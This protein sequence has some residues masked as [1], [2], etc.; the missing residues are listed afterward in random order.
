MNQAADIYIIILLVFGLIYTAVIFAYTVGWYKLKDFRGPS[1]KLPDIKASIIV[2]VRNEEENIGYLLQDLYKQDLPESTFEVIIADDDSTDSTVKIV[3]EFK[4]K[5]TGFQLK[6]LKMTDD[7]ES[8]A[9]KKRAIAEAI[10][11]SSGELIIT[12]D[13]DCRMGNQ[14]LKTL[15]SF[16]DQEKPKMIIGPVVFHH[17]KTWFE[18]LQTFEFLSLIAITAGAI[19]I[20]KPVMC[21]G[22][23]LL[24]EKKAYED[25]GGFGQNAFASGDDVFLLLKFKKIFGG[26]SVRFLKNQDSI[27]YTEAK[28]TPGDFFQ[29]RTRWASK[30]R[31]YD[32][33]ILLVSF[34]VFMVN[35]L[36]LAGFVLSL[37]NSA[38]WMIFLGSVL[39]KI[40]IDVPILAGITNFAS[41]K[42]LYLYVIPLVILYPVYIVMVGSMGIV[43]NYHWK[44]RK[45]KK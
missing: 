45:I 32:V 44:G 13:G 28:K 8:F 19:R 10:R 36:L 42:N 40:L 21:N 3:E 31:G 29:Q 37:M 33:K 41:K 30:N 5:H 1:A 12:T 15:L 9:F 22:A 25:T 11:N 26:K 18:N 2:P 38:L 35:F 34:T 43:G 24:Y 6:L 39:I 16:Y 27:V 17:E 20:G 23:N 7:D 4:N 14:W